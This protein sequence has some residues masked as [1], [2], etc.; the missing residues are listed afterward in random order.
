MGRDTH[1]VRI[2]SNRIVHERYYHGC[3]ALEVTRGKLNSPA[4][5]EFNL[6]VLNDSAVLS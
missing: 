4:G 5:G 1:L 3:S 2:N 6:D